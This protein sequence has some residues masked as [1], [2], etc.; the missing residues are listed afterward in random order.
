[1]AN[2]LC[3][4]GTAVQMNTLVGICDKASSLPK[5]GTHVGGGIHCNMPP[6]WDGSGA[7]PSGWTK[8]FAAFWTQT[9]LVAALPISNAQAAILQLPANLAKLTGPEAATLNAAIAARTQVDLEAG[10]YVPS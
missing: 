10:G 7:T 9:A 2:V 8:T 1:M 5:I 4:T 3:A 6:T